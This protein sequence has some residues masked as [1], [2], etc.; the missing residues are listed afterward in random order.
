[1]ILLDTNVV[2]VAMSREPHPRVREWLNDQASETLFL[3]SITVAELLF[4]NGALPEGKRKNALSA[5]FD[6][7]L[8]VFAARILP[9]DIP[10]ARSYADL[11]VVG[12]EV[13]DPWTVTR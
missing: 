3:S 11:A 9:F 1:M 5:A 4:G 8:D 10:A 2:S 13:I 6:D 7:V 12:L